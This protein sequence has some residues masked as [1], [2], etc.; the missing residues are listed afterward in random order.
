VG[1][2]QELRD[3]YVGESP[4]FQSRYHFLAQGGFSAKIALGS[5]QLLA[6]RGEFSSK[7]DNGVHSM[8]SKAYNSKIPTYYAMKNIFGST[9]K[10]ANSGIKSPYSLFYA[11]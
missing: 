5:A 11:A 8:F 7:I 1:H 10:N 6:A 4:T 2:A 9:F 3:R